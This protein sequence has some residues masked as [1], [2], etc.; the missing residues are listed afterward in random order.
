M[1]YCEND[2]QEWKKKVE[3]ETK[4]FFKPKRG[5]EKRGEKMITTY[6]CNRSGRKNSKKDN[7][8]RHVKCGGSIKLD[9]TCPAMMTVSME[10]FHEATEIEVNFQ[11]VH[12]GHE[13]ELGKLRLA[14]EE[15]I[16]WYQF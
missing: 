6:V 10:K 8:V 11:R 1:F 16:S 5:A 4:S 14:K 13:A 12:V 2:F 3:L 9:K 15:K 7:R